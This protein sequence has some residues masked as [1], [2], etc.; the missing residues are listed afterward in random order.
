MSAQAGNN[1]ATPHPASSPARSAFKGVVFLTSIFLVNFLSRLVLSPLFP[2]M[3]KELNFNHAQAGSIFLSGSVGYCA[4]LFLAGWVSSKLTHRRNILLSTCCIGLAM[5]LLASAE[6]LNG[7]RLGSLV[8]GV[9]GGLYLPS[10]IASITSL[11]PRHKFGWAMGIHELAPN[12]SFITVPILAE[13]VLSTAGWRGAPGFLAIAALLL[14]LAFWRFGK[15]SDLKGEPLNLSL[16]SQILTSRKLWAA[17]FALVLAVGASLGS[18][19]MLPL[20]LGS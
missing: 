16:I 3:E 4:G 5:L 15:A 7:L 18:F 1:R 20:F 12:L 6:S 14:G 2:E 10:G 9:S 19:A 13:I 11:V 17:A 8:A